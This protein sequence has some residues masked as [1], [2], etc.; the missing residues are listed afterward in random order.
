MGAEAKK[1]KVVQEV[2]EEQI[3][4]QLVLNVEKLHDIQEELDKINE[5]VV[6]KV[7]EI[8]QKYSEVRKPVYDKRED[9]IKTIPDFW[10]TAFMSHPLLCGLLSEEDQKIFKYLSSLEVEEFKDVQSGYSISFNFNSNPFFEDSKLTKSFTFLDEGLVKVTATKIKWKDGKGL[11]NGVAHDKKGNKRPHEEDE[12][13]FSWFSETQQEDDV[14]DVDDEIADA[15][16]DDL[17]PNPITYFNNETDEVDFE[18]DE[19]DQEE[20]GS[21]D[22]DIDG[23]DDGGEKDE[24]N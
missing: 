9:I 12:S 13:F 7:L 5:E 24:G 17:W 22:D 11:P 21:D 16:K 6:E 4:A 23:D 1:A 15:I 2:A 10:L 14:E 19:S 8:N 20:D 3:D 18:G